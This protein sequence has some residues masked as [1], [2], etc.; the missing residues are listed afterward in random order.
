MVERT[1]ASIHPLQ[2]LDAIIVAMVSNARRGH[3]LRVIGAAGHAG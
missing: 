3:V 1:C 2:R